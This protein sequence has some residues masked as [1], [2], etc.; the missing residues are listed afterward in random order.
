MTGNRVK[1]SV[2]PSREQP[3]QTRSDE[4]EGVRWSFKGLLFLCVCVG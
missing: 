2:Q 3:Q 4:G 1:A